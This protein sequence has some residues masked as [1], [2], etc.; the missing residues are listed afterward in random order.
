MTGERSR[1]GAGVL[2]VLVAAIVLTPFLVAALVLVAT[3]DDAEADAVRSMARAPAGCE[4]ELT[5]TRSGTFYVY[6]ELRGQVGPTD[7]DCSPTIRTFESEVERPVVTI[8]LW[9][10][11]RD[12]TL[13]SRSGITYDV[14]G[15]KGQ[16]VRVFRLDEPGTL[17]MRV[18]SEHDVAVAVGRDVDAVTTSRL[19]ALAYLALGGAVIGAGAG[20]GTG[21]AVRARR[22]GS[23]DQHGAGGPPT[24]VP[25][26]HWPT[27]PPL[28]GPGERPPGG[29]PPVPPPPTSP[30]IG[31]GPPTGPRQG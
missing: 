8:A 25:P 12:V 9:E 5:A 27:R 2:G 10:D 18:T 31:W 4:T 13:E 11:G 7:G 19:R 1:I 16:L 22:R 23:N 15:W 14:A 24:F 26:G 30:P 20:L 3:L 17:R 28:A 21:L 6:L 29:P